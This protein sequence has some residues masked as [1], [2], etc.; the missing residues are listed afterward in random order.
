MSTIIY[1]SRLGKGKAQSLDN[2]AHYLSASP[3][4]IEYLASVVCSPVADNIGETCGRINAYAASVSS[5][6]VGG[7]DIPVTT[8]IRHSDVV[9]FITAGDTQLHGPVRCYCCLDH[10]R[11]SGV[12]WK[13][14]VNGEPAAQLCKPSTCIQCRAAAEKGRTACKTAKTMGYGRGI[15]EH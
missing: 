8:L 9:W 13:P 3:L 6:G 5:I 15:T 12:G 2:T 7:R 1:Q 10:R 11:D 4:R 14:D